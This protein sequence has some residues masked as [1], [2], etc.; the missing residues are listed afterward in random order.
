MR[1]GFRLPTAQAVGSSNLSGLAIRK[2]IAK[3]VFMLEEVILHFDFN[4]EHDTWMPVE[5]KAE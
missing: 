5:D 4:Q 2:I 1:T 3:A